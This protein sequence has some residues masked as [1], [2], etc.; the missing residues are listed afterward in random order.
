MKY[1]LLTVLFAATAWLVGWNSGF[2]RGHKMGYDDAIIQGVVKVECKFKCPKCQSGNHS[3]RP[4]CQ[5]PAQGPN[6]AQRSF[7]QSLVPLIESDTN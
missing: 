6:S 3:D 2:D 5:V 4:T 1:L 7:F